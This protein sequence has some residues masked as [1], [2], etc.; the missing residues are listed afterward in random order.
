MGKMI[1]ILLLLNSTIAIAE[2]ETTYIWEKS[3]M[4]FYQGKCYEVDLETKG[5]KFKTRADEEKC[6]PDSVLYYFLPTEG[7]C[8]EVDEK[9]NGKIYAT[10]AAI[11]SCRPKNLIKQFASFRGKHG[12]YQVDQAT[13]GKVF[14]EYIDTQECETPDKSYLFK[15]E[16]NHKGNC[17]TKANDDIVKVDLELC[18]P[19]K[20]V[21]QFYRKSQLKGDC[22]EQDPKGE[23]YYSEKTQIENCRPKNTIYVFYVDEKRNK[24]NC[25]EID[26]ETKGDQY[27]NIVKEHFCKQ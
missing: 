13:Q 3:K 4:R 14:F 8:Y 10:K 6:R 20:P 7:K 17:Y 26:E 11:E 24:G 21:Y 5:K 12:C 15:L 9:T 1:L 22:F 16:G 23:N 18:R 2:M 25:Y 27:L 19:S